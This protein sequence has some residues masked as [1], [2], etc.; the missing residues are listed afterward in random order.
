MLTRGRKGTNSAKKNQ[1]LFERFG[2]NYND[3]PERM[4]KGSVVVR[5]EVWDSPC[6]VSLSAN[7]CHKVAKEDTSDVK[8]KG[9]GKQKGT[10]TRVTVLHCDLIRDEFWKERPYITSE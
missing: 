6:S 4:R 1:L 5:E 9:K 7:D 2:I 10:L 3:V 8:D